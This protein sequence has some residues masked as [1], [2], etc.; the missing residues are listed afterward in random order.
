MNTNRESKEP[1]LKLRVEQR[2]CADQILFA[3]DSSLKD[4]TELFKN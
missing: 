3:E 1:H 4:H 2:V